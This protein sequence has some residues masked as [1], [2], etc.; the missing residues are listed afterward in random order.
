MSQITIYKDEGAN[1]IF[2]EDA[3][4]VQFINSLQATDNNGDC[5]ISD[6]ARDIDI[7]SNEPYD[8]FIDQNGVLYGNNSTE[9]VNALN[10]I[11]QLSGTPTNEL[12]DITSAL[13]INSVQGDTINYE[14]TADFGVGYE[15][16]FSNV[17][18]ITTVDGNV[19]KI[20]GGSGL[21]S[22]TYNI[23]VKAI[24]YNGNDSKTIVLTVDTPAFANTKSV[25]FNLNDYLQANAGILQNVLGR[26]GNGSGSSDAWTIAFWFKAGTSTNAAQ[27]IFYFGNQD[28]ANNGYIQVKYNGANSGGK[29]IEFRYGTNNNRLTLLTATNSI[30]VDQWQHYIISYDG[31]T[32]G[33]NSADINNYYSR[34]KIFI[35]GAQVTTT[36]TNS[37]FGYSNGIVGQNFRIGRWNTSQYLR[38]NCKVDEIAVWDSDESASASDIYNGGVPKDFSLLTTEPKHWWRMGDGDTFPFLFDTGTE[39]NCTFVMQNMTSADIVN[40]VP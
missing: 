39:A 40:D 36:N 28:V 32:T 15:W 20:I 29:K 25:Q 30:T 37:N 11:F 34:F 27:T 24:N 14:L 5:S 18:G 26:T 12:P 7:V 21:S 22:G 4:G 6:L 31:G 35:D 38:N 16:D 2:I 9:V 17:S 13:T 1:A 10:A 3:N 33:T 19:R 8:Q 23:P